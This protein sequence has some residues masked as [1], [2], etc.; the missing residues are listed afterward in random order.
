MAAT[1]ETVAIPV[2]GDKN[3]PGRGRSV[4]E[5][6]PEQAAWKSR[7]PGVE[8]VRSLVRQQVDGLLALVDRSAGVVG[9]DR[10]EDDLRRLVFRL[11]RLVSV[12]FLALWHERLPVP[13]KQ[14]VG[15][16]RYRRQPAKG[17]WLG[18]FFGKVRYWRYYMH[19]TNGS[20]G[21]Y[22]PLDERLGLLADGFSF[23]ALARSVLLA[24]KMSFAAAALTLDGLL[25]WSPSTK[26]IERATL[27]LGRYTQEWFESAPAAEEDGDVLIIQV[28]SKATPTATEEELEKRRGE[29]PPNAHPESAR[30]RG[31]DKRQRRGPK[32]RRKKG[33]KSKNGRA[34]TIITMYTLKTTVLED[35]TPKLL[36]PVNRWV[37]ASYAPKRHAVA[38]ARREADKRGFT[39]DSGKTIQVLTDGDE[40]LERYFAEL[41]PEAIHTPDIVHVEEYIWKA[42]RCLHKE[43]S[44]RLERWAHDRIEELYEGKVWDMLETMNEVQHRVR[45]KTKVKNYGRYLDYILKR[46]ARMNCDDLRARDLELGTGMAEGAVRFV[47]GQRF[48]AAGMRW[49]R[50]RAEPLLQLRCIEINGDWDA[51]LAFAHQRILGEQRKRNPRLQQNRAGPLPTLGLAA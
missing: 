20:G 16:A 18:G 1:K 19:K 35:G 36:G 39:A 10:F 32:K 6:W 30:H 38:V 23:G 3:G 5:R 24:T 42:G 8:E 21:G 47:I 27:G 17:R 48:D 4:W 13:K 44:P 34:A 2:S 40:D 29:R 51:F 9:F 50:E 45:G 22:F 7:A 11:A 37:Y 49:I 31:R 46:A 33:D 25:G 28:D 14:K 15:K 43:A 26:T 12:L 41:F